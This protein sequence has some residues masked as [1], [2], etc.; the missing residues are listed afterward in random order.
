MKHSNLMIGLILSIVLGAYTLI[1]LPSGWGWAKS[2]KNQGWQ[3][4]QLKSIGE[5]ASC[6]DGSINPITTWWSNSRRIEMR[7]LLGLLGRI[8]SP[9]ATGS[10][11]GSYSYA[12]THPVP[13][14]HARSG[15]PR[16]QLIAAINAERARFELAPLGR[17][18]G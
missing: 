14:P 13:R 9:P 17:M 11:S 1:G 16:W 12:I 7:G 2:S 8:F 3:D 4:F 5:N 18:S 10:G 15:S 6:F